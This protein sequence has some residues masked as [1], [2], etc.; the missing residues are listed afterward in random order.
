MAKKR[1]I[2]TN[3]EIL[4]LAR[5]NARKYGRPMPATREHV[6]RLTGLMYTGP[7]PQAIGKT[8]TVEVKHVR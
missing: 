7:D 1:K 8:Y 2:K 5:A 3:A 4:E 6:E